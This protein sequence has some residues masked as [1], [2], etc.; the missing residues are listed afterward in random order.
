MKPP[1]GLTTEEWW[2][3]LKLGRGANRRE[4]PLG[5]VAGE[6]FSYSTP[7]IVQELLHRIDQDAGG[8][9]SASDQIL[10]PETRDRYLV[11]SLIEE[12][13]TSSQL[14]GAS[15]TKPVAKEM[16]RSGRK[17]KDRSEQMILNNFR[18][19]QL[20][21]E[22]KGSSLEPE[23]VLEI[24]SIVTSDTLDDPTASGRLR[25]PDEKGKVLV[26]DDEGHVLHHPPDALE[27]EA[28]MEAMCD[29]ANGGGEGFI[30]PVVR[31]I[32]LHFWLAYDH[33]FIDGNGRTARALFY[34]AM[35]RQS[36]WLTEF[37]SISRILRSAPAQY[38]RSF[39]YTETDENDLT[40]FLIYHLGVIRRALDAL[41]DDLRRKTNEMFEVERI[42]RRSDRFNHRQNAIL[43]HALRHPG[44][45][46]TIKSHQTSHNVVYQTARSDLLGLAD[47]NL[48][49]KRLV[50]KTYYFEVP[51]DLSDRL[52]QLD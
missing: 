11:S 44:F 27:L 23:H 35:L 50:G 5:D 33:P 47:T 52:Q 17:P 36:Y 32:V 12:A 20:I 26:V 10:K 49:R 1:P 25:D 15:T 31:A 34:W 22:S 4:V 19:M 46:Y 40:Y 41:Y 6:P 37:L 51:G 29:F 24:H 42:L 43:S 28:R 16:I 7:D 3:G 38:A 21:G 13:V 8:S 2:L 45:R 14:E 39:L 48:L 30:H 18:A 9:V